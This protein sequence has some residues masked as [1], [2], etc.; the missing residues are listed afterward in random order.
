MQTA[1]KINRNDPC[2]CGSGKKYKK[3][4]AKKE[5]ITITE[6]IDNEVSELQKELRIFAYQRYGNAIRSE[7]QQLMDKLEDT[8]KDD[9][10]FF[11]FMMPFWYIPFKTV[12][13]GETILHKFIEHKESAVLRPRL[14]EIL[15]SWKVAIPVAGKV[16]GLDDRDLHFVDTLTNESYTVV[17]D[18]AMNDFSEG[19]FAFGVLFPYEDKYTAFPCLFEVSEGK[20]ADYE[21]YLKDDFVAIGNNNAI[22]YLEDHFLELMHRLPEA[23]A[24]VDMDAYEWPTEGAKQVAEQF[25]KDMNAAGEPQWVINFGVGVWVEYIKQTNKRIQ[26]AENYIAALRYFVYEQSS[27][28]SSMT[29]KELGEKY[30]LTAGRVSTYY[31][32]IQSQV[33]AFI[34]DIFNKTKQE[35]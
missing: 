7:Y 15:Q 19:W 31:R 28:E 3:C 29:Q 11:E 22:Q 33:A 17:L 13:D 1:V 26:K 24:S 8:D 12:E 34:D 18:E 5:T 30:G 6:L 27:V 25:E 14:Q 23:A 2:P 21:G 9:A 32:D 16:T 4:C 10:E 20:A 35:A